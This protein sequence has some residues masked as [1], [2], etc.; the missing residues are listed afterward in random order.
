MA[1]AAAGSAAGG[2]AP[3][4]DGGRGP[5]SLL[6]P[7]PRLL[8]W[9]RIVDSAVGNV[10]SLH[11]WLK[12]P[13]SHDRALRPDDTPH[14]ALRVTAHA[15]SASP[16]FGPLLAHCGGPGS[17]RECSWNTMLTFWDVADDFAFF[18][19]DQRG[20]ALTADVDFPSALL[21]EPGEAGV[22]VTE[23]FEQ[24]S[25]GVVADPPSEG[26]FR[27]P[28]GVPQPFPVAQCDEIYARLA[29][30]TYHEQ[31]DR[32]RQMLAEYLGDAS[33][34]SE[35]EVDIVF[36]IL[37]AGG[38]PSD[39]V[40]GVGY[41][42]ETY[43]RWHYRLAALEQGLCVIAPRFT[44][45]SPT[46]QAYNSLAYAGTRELVR[47][48]ELLRRA[49]GAETISL[50]GFSYGTVVAPAYATLYPDRVGR[51]VVDGVV[52]PQ[53]D[54]LAFL[55]FYSRGMFSAWQGIM[56][57]CSDSVYR[58]VPEEERCSLAPGPSSKVLK[59]IH[60]RSNL[61]RAASVSN[62]M[63][64]S[65]VAVS[66]APLAVDIASRL[67]D[68]EALPEWC[69]E[70]TLGLFCG[71]SDTN[72]TTTPR[73]EP[74]GPKQDR[75]GVTMMAAVFGLDL[76]GRLSEEALVSWWRGS[77][78][79]FPIGTGRGVLLAAT[80]GSWPLYPKPLPPPGSGSTRALVI[81]NLHD[82]QTD[83]S[84]AQ[85]MRA[86]YPRGALMTWQGYGHCLPSHSFEPG[87]NTTQIANTR[88]LRRCLGQ[89]TRYMATDELPEDGHIC[90][91]DGPLSFAID[92]ASAALQLLMLR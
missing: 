91:L 58:G 68:G 14:V 33:E 76:S 75:F 9:D 19:I 74:L 57:D 84:G 48:I 73:D 61:T 20:I 82:A 79:Q 92:Y 15:R 54:L 38:V 65:T 69:H 59:M 50:T 30:L 52:P 17:G 43:V 77:L 24:L 83:Y 66:V 6:R 3:L 55:T 32:V 23:V 90:E 53:P 5:F 8:V 81:G 35:E 39:G 36:A 12:V 40:H 47:D 85:S 18:G 46:G 87:D 88:S 86:A 44:R 78:E 45:T 16:R 27:G 22:N 51:L 13:L 64:L 49:V 89:V 31:V 70:D 21:G 71:G 41:L 62:L 28:G 7:D 2:T 34:P 67:Y 80:L 37:R 11:G 10:T 4:L 25:G 26:T 56:T 42:N 63:T 29:N 1:L 60:D 72:S